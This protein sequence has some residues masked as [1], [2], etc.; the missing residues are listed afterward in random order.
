[1]RDC[2]D[3][4]AK[5]GELHEPGC[6]TDRCPRCGGQQISCSCIYIVNGMDPAT[7]EE[8]HP[9]I[10]SNGPT[11]EMYE[12]FDAEWGPRRLPWTGEYPGSAECRE[13]GF[14]CYWDENRL[15]PW[16]RCDADHPKAGPDLNR[17]M[18]SC[19]WDAEKGKFVLP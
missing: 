11:D 7:L 5:P 9:D 4:G 12:R 1:M 6:D 17:L 16:V 19:R 15:T 8:D 2:H 10:F 13:Y 3:C 14:W 18:T